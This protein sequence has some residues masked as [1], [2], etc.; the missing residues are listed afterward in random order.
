MSSRP[1]RCAFVP[2]PDPSI[3]VDA[4]CRLW[5]ARP[6][7]ACPGSG[8]RPTRAARLTVA[9]ANHRLLPRL[10]PLVTGEMN[11]AKKRKLVGY[12]IKTTTRAMVFFI[13]SCAIWSHYSIRGGLELHVGDA[14]ERCVAPSKDSDVFA[15]YVAID[16]GM[17][18]GRWRGRRMSRLPQQPCVG[19]EERACPW[20]AC[21]V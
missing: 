18:R 19:D 1:R 17:R 15:Q 8:A 20:P 11:D 13:M 4:P 5:W 12:V 2:R 9:V 14:F 3:F 7:W 16:G 10:A 6:V 21:C